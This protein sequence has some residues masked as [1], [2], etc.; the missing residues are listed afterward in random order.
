MIVYKLDII[1]NLCFQVK[2]D[3][4]NLNNGHMEQIVRRYTQL[5]NIFY[6]LTFS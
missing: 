4:E 2:I 3:F 6:V 5:L 1:K